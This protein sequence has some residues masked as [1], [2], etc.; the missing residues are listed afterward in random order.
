MT[1]SDL[2]RALALLPLAAAAARAQTGHG[3]HGAAA[4]DAAPS[5]AAYRQA[6]AR[7]HAAMDI[8]YSGDADV[9]FARG[10]IPHHRGAIDMARVELEHGS[11]PELRALAEQI[12]AAQEAEIA[13]LDAW[14]AKNDR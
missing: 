7:M 11:D 6:A 1:R 5:T 3:D 2:L 10:M 13:F 4:A 8:P 14:L 9:D 12:I